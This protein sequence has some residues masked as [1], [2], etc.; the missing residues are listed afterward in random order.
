MTPT[1]RL[2]ITLPG[3]V[4]VAGLVTACGGGGGDSGGSTTPP[5]PPPPVAVT[6][7]LELTGMSLEDTRTNTAVDPT[8]LPIAGATASRN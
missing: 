1:Q 5:P 8:G 7:T 6:Y 3:L 2:S 4:L